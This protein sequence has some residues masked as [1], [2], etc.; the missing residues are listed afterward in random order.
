MV[1]NNSENIFKYVYSVLRVHSK[2]LV[3]LLVII[4]YNYNSSAGYSSFE[5]LKLN[6]MTDRA[7]QCIAAK[8][9]YLKVFEVSTIMVL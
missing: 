8:S 1:C 9:D 5:W 2:N 7:S 6:H 3:L 4:D